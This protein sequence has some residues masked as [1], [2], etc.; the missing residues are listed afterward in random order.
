VYIY[1]YNISKHREMVLGALSAMSFSL[2]HPWKIFP[3]IVGAG[4]GME[5][6]MVVILNVLD[7][8]WTVD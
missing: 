6:C 3:G 5:H 1:T 2:F 4:S 7:H 8:N